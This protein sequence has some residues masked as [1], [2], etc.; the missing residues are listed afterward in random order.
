MTR[1][2]TIT[3]WSIQPLWQP[4][5]CALPGPVTR[6]RMKGTWCSV[7]HHV[8]LFVL[9]VCALLVDGMVLACAYARRVT[10]MLYGV[11]H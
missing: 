11:S 2:K 5:N 6:R 10:H 8:G 7:C 3:F 4:L 9:F 1:N